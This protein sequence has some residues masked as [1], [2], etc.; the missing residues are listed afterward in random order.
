MSVL[1]L[2][3]HIWTSSSIL[4]HQQ[5]RTCRNGTKGLLQPVSPLPSFSQPTF[6]PSWVL[7]CMV[8]PKHRQ[9]KV[10]SRSAH[11]NP[12]H[13]NHAWVQQTLTR[14]CCCFTAT[15]LGCRTQRHQH[16]HRHQQISRECK[17]INSYRGPQKLSLEGH[18]PQTFVFVC[19]CLLLLSLLWPNY[20]PQK[21]AP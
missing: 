9:N 8:C 17:P 7:L 14:L 20:L 16:S 6:P 1:L 11:G 5:A 10:G 19:C 12:A 2:V 15:D 21:P 18:D 13:L 3:A 4:L